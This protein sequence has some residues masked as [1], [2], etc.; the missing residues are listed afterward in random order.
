VCVRRPDDESVDH[1]VGIAAAEIVEALHVADVMMY[2]SR[3]RKRAQETDP[4]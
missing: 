2:V 3:S 4:V 1:H